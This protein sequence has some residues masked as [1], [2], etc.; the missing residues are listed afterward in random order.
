MLKKLNIAHPQICRNI[1]I[2]NEHWAEYT[3]KDLRVLL[4]W[5]LSGTLRKQYY[6]LR[7]VCENYNSET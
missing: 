3:Q 5:I 6:A 7:M 4:I 1:R 2:K